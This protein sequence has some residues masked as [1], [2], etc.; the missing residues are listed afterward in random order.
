M[1]VVLVIVKKIMDCV[2]YS[3][4]RNK[5]QVSIVGV[6][7][8]QLSRTAGCVFPCSWHMSDPRSPSTFTNTTPAMIEM[9]VF[10][11]ESRF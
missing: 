4:E 9:R 5:G 2:L 3:Q 11:L 7:R 10:A 6:A 8:I 1:H